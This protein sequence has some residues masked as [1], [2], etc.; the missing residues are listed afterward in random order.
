MGRPTAS[1]T[2]LSRREAIKAA[3]ALA[4]AP[5][6]A[7]PATAAPAA[8][9]PT[10]RFFTR[11]QFGLVDELAE[12]IIPADEQS[13]GARAAGVAAYIDARLAEAFEPS[14]RQHWLD[15]LAAIDAFAQSVHGRPFMQASPDQREVV[16]TRIAAEES[17]PTTA[18]GKFFVELKRW[19]VRGYYTSKIGIHEDMQ[20]KGNTLQLGDYAGLL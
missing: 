11:A 7:S 4:A 19:T 20:Y 17:Q 3:A 6:A 16:M 1:P 13:P 2:G 9:E 18:E 14:I 8:A 10:L 12:M 15:G 5:L